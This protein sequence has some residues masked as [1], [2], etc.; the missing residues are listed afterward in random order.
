[1]RPEARLTQ[2]AEQM[3][4]NPDLVDVIV[5]IQFEGII[6]SLHQ[7]RGIEQFVQ[8]VGGRIV[9]PWF[10]TPTAHR[11]TLAHPA[12]IAQRESTICVTSRAACGMLL[13]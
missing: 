5:K 12:S 7:P 13:V 11:D 8:P 2:C 6:N 10:S 3:G 9:G 4:C 1:M